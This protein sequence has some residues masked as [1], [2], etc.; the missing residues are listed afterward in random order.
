ME[1]RLN[2][3]PFDFKTGNIVMNLG[4]WTSVSEEIGYILDMKVPRD[5]F[6][7]SA[8]S[9]LNNLANQANQMGIDMKIGDIIELKTLITGTLDDPKLKIDLVGTGKGIIEEA[10]KTIEEGVATKIDEEAK[11]IL[12]EAQ[13]RADAILS[14]AQEEADKLMVNA[15]KLAEETRNQVNQNA[16]KIEKEAEDKGS[17]AKLAAKKAAD[18]VRK[19]G[20]KQ[21]NN[22]VNE[23]KKQSDKILEKAKQE[24]DKI[25]QEA[26][27][28]AAS[29]NE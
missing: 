15:N 17:L 8:S 11:K 10:K 20:D 13:A 29:L 12:L 6:G 24:S 26:R 23:A 19:E 4:G 5:A 22:I 27:D 18:E 7:A 3:K 16:A 28:K 1:G 2:V 9:V 25:L 21:A 14:K